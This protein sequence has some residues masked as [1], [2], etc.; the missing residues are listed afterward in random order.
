[1]HEGIRGE[2]VESDTQDS[3]V[4]AGW[5]VMA[6]PGMGTLEDERG[7]GQGLC[8]HLNC[9]GN[10]KGEMLKKQCAMPVSQKRDLA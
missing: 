5:V 9:F 1:M 8:F 2:G 6:V 3:G 4:T 7:A 10:L